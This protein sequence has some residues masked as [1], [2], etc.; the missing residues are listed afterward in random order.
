MTKDSS[1]GGLEYTPQ[2]KKLFEMMTGFFRSKILSIS[3]ERDLF[4]WVSRRPRKLEH[5]QKHLGFPERPALIFMDALVNM[6]LLVVADGTFKNSSMAAKYLVRGRLAYQGHNISLFDSLYES[7]ADLVGVLES[8][9]PNNKSYTYFFDN[10]SVEQNVDEYSTHMHESA[11]GPVMVLHEIVDFSET[12]KILDVGGGYGR[13]CMTLVSQYSD[14][15]AILFD[16]PEVCERARKKLD[17]FWLSHRITVHPGDFFVDDFPSGAD[18]ILMMRITHDWSDQ[19]LRILFKKAYDALPSGGRLLV[20]E[21]IKKEERGSPGDAAMVSLLLL[22]ISP[23]G[24]CRTPGDL[25]RILKDVGFATTEVLH[26]IY[27]YSVIE[28]RKA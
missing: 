9:Q 23:G 25:A 7:G 15:E 5:F 27:I 13:T 8:G 11:T 4:T 20:Y 19:H 16:L 21:T 18:T 2:E 28:A 14:L 12:K 17:G 1:G 6:G 22:M 26:A 24:V 10:N 3:V